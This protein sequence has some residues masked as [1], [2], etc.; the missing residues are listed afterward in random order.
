MSQNSP[1][2]YIK[3][4]ELKDLVDSTTNALSK[5][6]EYVVVCPVCQ[7][8]KGPSYQKES[9]ILTRPWKSDTALFVN[10]CF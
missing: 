1:S 8:L 10:Q 6:G 2:R 9:C 3:T 7:S 5:N 4:Y